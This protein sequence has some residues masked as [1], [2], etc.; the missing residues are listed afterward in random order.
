MHN[1]IEI[2][3]SRAKSWSHGCHS[4]KL[5]QLP[6]LSESQAKLEPWASD[7]ALDML[8]TSQYVCY[9]LSSSASNYSQ[10][11]AKF[12][13]SA[14]RAKGHPTIWE[15]LRLHIRAARAPSEQVLTEE[16]LRK[17][18]Q[19]INCKIFKG[20]CT[21]FSW[22]WFLILCIPIINTCWHKL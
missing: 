20:I 2:D 12:C 6:Q 10:R 15:E 5:G 9:F 14:V 4:E 7:P 22:I 1:Y 16:D 13:C 18:R 8:L 21:F 3:N 17:W 11:W 19:E